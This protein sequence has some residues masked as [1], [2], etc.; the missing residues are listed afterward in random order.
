LSRHEWVQ[1]RSLA[2]GKKQA[3]GGLGAVVAV[4]AA[5]ALVCGTSIASA[6]TTAPSGRA[7]LAGTVPAV[8]S[9]TSTPLAAGTQVQ[10]SV[11]VGQNQAGLAAAA[12]AVSDPR[13]PNYRHYLRP[14][15]VQARFGAN[16]AQQKAV[17]T[18]LSAAGLTVTHGDAFTIT[19]EG[20]ATNA[21]AAV[22]ASLALNQPARSAAQVLPSRAMSV[23]STLA[24]TITTIRVSTAASLASELHEQLQSKA[25]AA[26]VARTTAVHSATASATSATTPTAQ[27][28]AYY[29]QKP[30]TGLPQAYGRTIDWAP[31]G[32]TPAQVRDAYGAT[33]SGLT[34]TGTTVAVLSEIDDPT[35]LSD[36][37]HWSQQEHI[38]PFAPGQFTK[39]VAANAGG[40]GQEEDAMDIEAVHGMAPAAKIDYVAGD[41]SITGD[42]ELDALDTVVQGDLANVATTSWYEGFMSQPWIT[43]SMITSWESVL[44]QA[45]LE[46]ITVDA[47]SGDYGSSGLLQYPSSDPWIT[48]VGGTTLAIGAHD[49]TLWETGW[50]GADTPLAADGQSWSPAPP[51][52]PVG[53]STGGVSQTF[54]EPSYQQGVVSGN[55]VNG[56]AMRTVPDVSAFADGDV[57]YQIG[58]TDYNTS[59]QT[60]YMSEIGGGTSLS[61]PLFAGFEADL[62]QGRGGNPLGFANP[63]LYAHTNTPAFRDITADPQGPRYTEAVVYQPVSFP[64]ADPQ[65]PLTLDTEGQCGTGSPLVCGPGYD[66]VTGIGSPG[67]AFFHSFGSQPR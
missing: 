44:E 8:T 61:A 67:P 53:G 62:I 39:Y 1:A 14:A 16:E 24:G 22:Q 58:L 27:C 29:G 15:Q 19:A 49:N 66:M 59:G 10:L 65:P 48:A 56:E 50:A 52:S 20:P 11:F 17:R 51:G 4:T 2:R 60:V 3:R 31:C 43:Q 41:G 35:A 33:A 38:P 30:A 12:T 40:G 28:S 34:G 42:I 45:A 55:T 26:P 64:L 13:S 25:S 63:L 6:A 54:A 47:A 21:E 32:Y 36:A 37:N 18:W 23:P 7:L 57:G 9:G 46:G 5:C